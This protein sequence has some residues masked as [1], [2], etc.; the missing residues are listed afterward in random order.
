MTC[1]RDLSGWRQEATRRPSRD[2]TAARLQTSHTENS[3]TALRRFV[4]SSNSDVYQ[5]SAQSIGQCKLSGKHSPEGRQAM[6]DGALLSGISGLS[7]NSVLRIS[8]LLLLPCLLALSVFS[9]FLLM[10]H[11]PDFFVFQNVSNVFR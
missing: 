8:S 11:S 10:V 6:S 9:S 7:F 1:R 3:V 4:L 2:V 5:D